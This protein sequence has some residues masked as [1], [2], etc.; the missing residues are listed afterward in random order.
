MNHA[1]KPT[2]GFTLIELMLAM[3]FVSMLL[4]GVALI[5]IQVGSTYNRGLTIKAVNQAGRD[6]NDS[7]R[8][9]ISSSKSG[10]IT[11][12][13]QTAGGAANLNRLCLGMQSYVWNYGKAINENKA[14]T[15]LDT[16]KPI[17]LAR[18]DDPGATLCKQASGAYP[19]VV[20]SANSTELL[21]SESLDLALHQ[22]T[23]TQV[24]VDDASGQAA[25]SVQYTL[26]TNDQSVLET[27][28]RQCRPPEGTGEQ[29]F[30]FCAVNVFET[31]IRAGGAE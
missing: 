1:H 21:E 17:V 2:L 20:N 8:R 31:I 22:L 23:F 6:V 28:N 18:V 29:N 25:Y 10:D 7:L 14:V 9:D 19:S 27:S 11:L 5:T 26:G 13:P 16:G 4:L 15:Y 24:L 3:S 30:E 12:V